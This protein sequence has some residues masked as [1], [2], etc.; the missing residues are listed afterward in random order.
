MSTFTPS[1][2]DRRSIGRFCESAVADYLTALGYTIAAR[3]FTV[4]GGEIDLIAEDDTTLLFVEVKG[5]TDGEQIRRFGRPAT[6]VNA[7]K[8]EHLLFAA[9]EYIR[10]TGNRKKPRL[11]VA[12]VYMTPVEAI[13][14]TVE[15]WMALTIRYYPAA[16]R[17]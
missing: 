1:P 17:G 11:D 12:E 10:R 6:A 3:G 16:F 14:D 15:Q 13:A 9:K 8:Q 5:R 2:A 7:A 4:K